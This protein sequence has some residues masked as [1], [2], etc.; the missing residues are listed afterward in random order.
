M[1]KYGADGVRVGML[2]TSPAGNDLPF[3]E[4]L[5]EQG[6]N[7]SNKIWNALRLL[8]GWDVDA[9]I[10][11]PQSSKVSVQWFEARLNESIGIIDEQYRKYRISEAL[12]SVYKLI[13]DD[14]CSWYLEMIKPEYGKAI[15][16]VTFDATVVFFEK[17]MQLLHPFMPFITEEIWHMLHECIIISLMPEKKRYSHKTLRQFDFAKDVIVAIRNVRKEKNIPVREEIELSVKKN[18]GEEPDTTFDS[19]AAKLC[20]LSGVN[21]V[22]QKVEGALTFIVRSTEFYI[23]LT[24]SVDVEAEIKKLEDELAYMQGFLNTVMKKLGNE[25]FV[26]GAPKNVVDLEL[27]KKADAEAKIKVIEE[28]LV[29]LRGR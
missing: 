24:S 1:S 28:Q 2:F 8:K 4:V 9:G 16:K 13:W 10:R 21:Y 6:R 27:K 19:V 7:F 12:M 29:M 11:Q 18:F 3:D 15:D 17:L 26:A 23:P 25:R 5:C 20:N 14:F 22:D